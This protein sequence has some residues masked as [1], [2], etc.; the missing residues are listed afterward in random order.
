HVVG[1]DADVGRPLL[2]QVEHRVDDAAHTAQLAG[3]AH[4]LRH[5]VEVAEKLVRPVDQMHLHGSILTHLLAP[6]CMLCRRPVSSLACVRLLSGWGR[7]SPT[8]AHVVDLDDTSLRAAFDE[9]GRGT[10]ARGL[11]RSYGD[12]AQ[13]AGGTVLDATARAATI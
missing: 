4:V 6:A 9:R 8:A 3:P 11:G 13:N 12:A 2:Q 7:T 1:G 5:P 10:L